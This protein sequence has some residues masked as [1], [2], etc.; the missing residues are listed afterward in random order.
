MIMK[1]VSS[2]TLAAFLAACSSVPHDK[3]NRIEIATYDPEAIVTDAPS[4]EK[5][6]AAGAATGAFVGAAGG[7]LYTGLLSLVCGP[8][9]AAC[10]AGAAPA[11]VGATAVGGGVV[12]AASAS[13]QDLDDLKEFIGPLPK[14]GQ[15]NKELATA[16]SG[17]FEPAR[18]ADAGNAD[19]RLS[20]GIAELR[21]RQSWGKVHL[22]TSASARFDWNLGRDKPDTATRSYACTTIEESP[23]DWPEN[24]A[25]LV[26]KGLDHCI[27]DLAQQI[28][29]AL[30]DSPNP[31]PAGFSETPY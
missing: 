13:R 28:H 2:F 8:F 14:T 12:G 22:L 4:K 18:V 10:F 5:S 21:V 29:T 11:V 23:V 20:V 24:S 3:F 16:V 1:A 17:I 31:E 15:L 27:R 30:T 26:R 25:E 9:F 7:L 19:A 6:A